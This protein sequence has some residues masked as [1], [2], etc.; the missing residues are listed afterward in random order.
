MESEE[1][2]A[3]TLRNAKR[4]MIFV[5][6]V[7]ISLSNPVISAKILLHMLLVLLLLLLGL[8][9]RTRDWIGEPLHS[10]HAVTVIMPPAGCLYFAASCRQKAYS[11]IEFCRKTSLLSL[12]NNC[13]IRVEGCNPDLLYR[14]S[15]IFWPST[16]AAATVVV[17]K[18]HP[19]KVYQEPAVITAY[20]GLAEGGRT[21]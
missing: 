18:R 9:S 6:L 17:S 11:A 15:N 5:S 8:Y 2:F 13:L 21:A 19:S 20:D 12:I 10:P 3:K 4:D 16:A 14:K 1:P 7:V